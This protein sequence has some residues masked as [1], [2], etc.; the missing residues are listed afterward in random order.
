[1]LLAMI[2]KSTGKKM[3]SYAVR[4]LWSLPDGADK[5]QVALHQLNTVQSVLL[6]VDGK[7]M[8]HQTAIERCVRC[9]RHGTIEGGGRKGELRN[10][11]DIRH[12]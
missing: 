11:G 3:K 9:S 7:L 12:P 6:A 5:K 10:Q 4:V 8:S 2:A 1:M